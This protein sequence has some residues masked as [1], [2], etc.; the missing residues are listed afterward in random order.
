MISFFFFFNNHII[1]FTILYLM[2][3]QNRVNEFSGNNKIY[4]LNEK[5]IEI[6]SNREIEGKFDN[7]MKR[8]E[9]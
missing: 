5:H 8:K 2:L 7:G 4:E 3:V 1:F 9:I 6:L